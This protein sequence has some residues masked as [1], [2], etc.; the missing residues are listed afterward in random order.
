VTRAY[1]DT[2]FLYGHLRAPSEHDDPR[3][4]AWRDRVLS[5]MADDP[6]VISAPVVD[7]LAYRLVLAWLRDDGASDPLTTFR[8]KADEAMRRVRSRL[9]DVWEAVDALDLDL[10]TTGPST[11]ERAKTL[12]TRPGLAPR[13]AFHAA[14]ALESSCDVIVSSDRAFERVRGLRRIAPAR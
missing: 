1:L 11:V 4:T 12:M 7:E 14:H 9:A 10:V 5:L 2:N 3:F 8:A 13:D 6:A